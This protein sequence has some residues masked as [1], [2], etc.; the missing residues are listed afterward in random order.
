MTFRGNCI[1][2]VACCYIGQDASRELNL[3]GDRISND[4]GYAGA[5]TICFTR[6][7][8]NLEV[9]EDLL[10]DGFFGGSALARPLKEGTV[11]YILSAVC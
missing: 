1:V 8:G 6:F 7:G 5:Q 3:F 10:F 4:V 9:K 11:Q 2:K